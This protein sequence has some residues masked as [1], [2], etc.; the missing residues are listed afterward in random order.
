MANAILG[1]PECAALRAAQTASY[2]PM[3]LYVHS[4]ISFL[5]FD[6]AVYG[7]TLAHTGFVKRPK[8]FDLVLVHKVPDPWGAHVAV[9]LGRGLVLHLSKKIG[10]P[11]IESLQSMMLRAQ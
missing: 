6:P 3:N 4:A 5:T 2:T 7:K 9:Y 8:P 10:E 1:R 11:V